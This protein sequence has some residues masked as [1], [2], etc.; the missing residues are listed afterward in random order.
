MEVDN[1][2]NDVDKANNEGHDEKNQSKDNENDAVNLDFVFD[3]VYK[4]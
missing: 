3:N 4:I 2:A 1:I